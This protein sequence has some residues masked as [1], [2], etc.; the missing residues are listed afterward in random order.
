MRAVSVRRPVRAWT[1]RGSMTSHILGS[2]TTPPDPD[3]DRREGG[4]GAADALA[5][6]ARRTGS[7][8]PRTDWRATYARILWTSD[9]AALALVVFGTQIAWFGLGSA[10]VS[11]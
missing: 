9:L 8:S 11:I 7:S 1:Q 10:Q 3:P 4:A 5:V 6:G 2:A